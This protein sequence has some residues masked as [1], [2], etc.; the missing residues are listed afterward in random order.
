LKK[1]AAATVSVATTRTGFNA[2]SATA[3]GNAK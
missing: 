2:G 3:K 1:G